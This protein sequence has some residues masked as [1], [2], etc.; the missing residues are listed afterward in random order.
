MNKDKKMQ[1]AKNLA[2]QILLSLSNE[3]CF[4][5]FVTRFFTRTKCINNLSKNIEL[6]FRHGETKL[7]N[8]NKDT[9]FDIFDD[10][11]L[12]DALVWYMQDFNLSKE[13]EAENETKPK[14]KQL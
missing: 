2:R 10:T 1:V 7:V 11:D 9:W 8:W 12:V 6:Y 14:K 13:I 5:G 3:D 4:D